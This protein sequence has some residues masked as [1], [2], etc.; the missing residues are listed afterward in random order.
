MTN[1]PIGHMLKCRFIVLYPYIYIALLPAVASLGLVSPGAVTH[2]VT[3]FTFSLR[4]PCK[5]CISEVYCTT[6]IS[7]LLFRPTQYMYYWLYWYRIDTN[8]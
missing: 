7:A 8:S 6:V 3:S 5:I 4:R 2:G 1:A